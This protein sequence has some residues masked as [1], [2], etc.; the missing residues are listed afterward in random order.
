LIERV[1]VPLE[2]RRKQTAD[3]V[4]WTGGTSHEGF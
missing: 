4:D 2:F 1:K 3:L